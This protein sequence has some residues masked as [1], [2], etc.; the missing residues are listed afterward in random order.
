MAGTLPGVEAARR[1][2]FHQKS[3]LC[4]NGP[5]RHFSPAMSGYGGSFTRRPSFCLYATN[6]EFRLCSNLRNP[7]LSQVSWDDSRLGAEAREA[8]KRLDERLQPQ[9]RSETKR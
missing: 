4:Y 1:R 7:I 3:N 6:H 2:R 8:K 5:D 9:W